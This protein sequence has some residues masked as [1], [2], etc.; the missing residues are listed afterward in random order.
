LEGGRWPKYGK[1]LSVSKISYLLKSSKLWSFK[2]SFLPH[3]PHQCFKGLRARF[4]SELPFLCQLE[5]RDCLITN[6]RLCCPTQHTLGHWISWKCLRFV[7]Y[8]MLPKL[9]PF[10][11]QSCNFCHMCLL[12]AQRLINILFKLIES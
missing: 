7:S 11:S 12:P 10:V 5:E 8:T 2:S 9:E 3:P 6:V 4:L 1:P